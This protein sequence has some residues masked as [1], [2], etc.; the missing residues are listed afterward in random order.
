ME[1][2]DADFDISQD[3]TSM[4]SFNAAETLRSVA[5]SLDL[6]IGTLGKLVFD[7]T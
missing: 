1:Q 6:K 2:A 4:D 7:I 3:F 5:W